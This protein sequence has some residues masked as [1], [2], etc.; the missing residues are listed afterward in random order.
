MAWQVRG[1]SLGEKGL[2]RG[3]NWLVPDVGRTN[4]TGLPKSSLLNVNILIRYKQAE[5]QSE[6]QKVY[7][8]GGCMAITASP[9][10]WIMCFYYDWGIEFVKAFFLL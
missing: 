10:H 7:D 6:S 3:S 4:W 8:H 1:T 2:V 9:S 5:Y